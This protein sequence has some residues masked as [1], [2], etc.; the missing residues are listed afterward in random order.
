[1]RKQILATS[2][3]AMATQGQ[4]QD[5][6]TRLMAEMQRLGVDTALVVG[7]NSIDEHPL[8]SPDMQY[9]AANIMGVWYSFYLS[10]FTLDEAD[11]HA[12]KI[13]VPNAEPRFT[14][15]VEEDITAITSVT[16]YGSRQVETTNG[17][18]IA[19][20]QSGVSAGFSITKPG[21]APQVLWRSDMENCHSLSLSPSQEYVAFLCEINGLFVHRLP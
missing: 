17:T 2:V 3:A 4:A 19:L 12:Q 18:V 10:S 1:M 6:S 13:G 11:W 16:I 7:S 8:W 5:T 15:A 20:A 14:E 9:I 21:E